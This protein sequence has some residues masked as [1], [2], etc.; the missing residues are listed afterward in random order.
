MLVWR[1]ATE[2]LAI[3][4]NNAI[5]IQL[6]SRETV[7]ERGHIRDRQRK[8]WCVPFR[9]TSTGQWCVPV[10]PRM[11]HVAGRGGLPS[12]ASAVNIPDE[13]RTSRTQ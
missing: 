12:L 11:Q 13:D 7:V 10:K 5:G 1:F 8:S 4:C 9:Q 3:A 6:G 2:P